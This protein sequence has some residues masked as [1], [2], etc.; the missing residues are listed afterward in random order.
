MLCNDHVDLVVALSL[1]GPFFGRG[2]ALLA[3]LHFCTVHDFC[4]FFLHF[5]VDFAFFAFFRHFLPLAFS[6]SIIV[7]RVFLPLLCILILWG[8]PLL[9]LCSL[10]SRGREFRRGG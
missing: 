4:V 8:F 2:W 10:G 1:L 3:F 7:P 9:A 6:M 5:F